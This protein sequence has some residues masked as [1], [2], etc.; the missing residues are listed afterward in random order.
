[1]KSRKK[2]ISTHIDLEL[3][4]SDEDIAAFSRSDTHMETENYLKFLKEI[5][6]LFPPDLSRRPGPKGESFCL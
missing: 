6:I 1:M 4:F 3:K 2:E 5:N